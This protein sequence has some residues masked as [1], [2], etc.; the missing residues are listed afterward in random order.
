[1]LF[2]SDT[3]LNGDRSQKY[4]D[5]ILRNFI[6]VQVVSLPFN[7]F[8]RAQANIKTS[9]IHLRKKRNNETQG[10]IFMAIT[11]NVGHDDHSNATPERDNLLNVARVFEKWW[12]TG[13][14]STVI[15]KPNEDPDEPLGCPLQ[16]FELP[17]RKL[18]PKRLDAFYYSPELEKIR[19]RL[20]RLERQGKVALYR[21][22]DFQ[23]I[24]E[25]SEK[26]LGKD[27]FRYFEISDVTRDGIVVMDKTGSIR[28]LPTRARLQVSEGDVIFAKNISSRGT[29]VL[30]PRLYHNQLTTTGFV[31]IRP[32]DREDAL[33]LWS[34]LRS[35]IFRKQVYYLSITAS[36]PE[37]RDDAFDNEVL[38]PFPT[39][40]SQR[41]EIIK[42]ATAAAE[43]RDQLH[44]I[45]E[46]SM[47]T[48][49]KALEGSTPS[50]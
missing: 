4:R 6:I 47:T 23:R 20:R 48:V 33:M 5:F 25:V 27:V 39:D 46:N 16:V 31:G 1:V 24:T 36:Q 9:I 18:D 17:A 38:I 15:E 30:I 45:L 21:G 49:Q 37:L 10:S 41:K 12:T 22:R 29:T 13:K 42:V 34:I 2:R 44:D 8:F 26:N 19:A 43:T 32:R 7:T 14:M 28:E 40:N 3:V 11:N 35:E 50:C